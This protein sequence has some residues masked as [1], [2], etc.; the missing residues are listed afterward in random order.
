MQATIDKT[1]ALRHYETYCFQI[2]YYLLEKE[3]L[4]IEAV[5]QAFIQ[6]YKNDAF[7]SMGEMEQ[8]AHM[9]QCVIRHALEARKQC[10]L[11]KQCQHVS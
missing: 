10:L 3:E 6:I 1:A 8:R 11:R 4:A 9:K 5:S 7:F 2:S